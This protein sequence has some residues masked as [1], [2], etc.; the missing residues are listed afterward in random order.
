MNVLFL[1][2]V[3]RAR[4]RG[5]ARLRAWRVGEWVIW[6]GQPTIRGEPAIARE[7][8]AAPLY[9]VAPRGSR[10]MKQSFASA[11]RLRGGGPILT[12]GPR[13]MFRL[14]SP[15]PRIV[16]GQ[17]GRIDPAGRAKTVAC[18]PCWP[19]RSDCLP[20]HDAVRHFASGE[21]APECDKQLACECDDHF[22]FARAFDAIGPHSTGAM[23]C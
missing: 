8:R 16:S 7:D 15:P 20:Q 18:A 14:G 4:S 21:H 10:T 17:P 19:G 2:P 12:N 13:T 5:V 3:N 22:R 11:A 23:R 1:L 9:S 6:P